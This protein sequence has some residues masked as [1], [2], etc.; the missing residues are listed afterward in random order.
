MQVDFVLMTRYTIMSEVK[1]VVNHPKEKSP[2]FE[3]VPTRQFKLMDLVYRYAACPAKLNSGDRETLAEMKFAAT[4]QTV[5][6]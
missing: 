4:Q 2:F 1:Y 5:T 6:V 3:S